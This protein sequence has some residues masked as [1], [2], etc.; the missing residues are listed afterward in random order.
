[1]ATSRSSIFGLARREGDRQPGRCAH[2][3]QAQPPVEPRVRGAVA[4]AG[5]AGERRTFRRSAPSRQHSTGV[6]VDQPGVVG[7]HV[8]VFGEQA[9][10]RLQLH[11]R[12]CAAACCSRPDQADTGT[13]AVE[14]LLGRGAASE[15]RCGEAQQRLHHRQRQQLGV[16]Q[17]RRDADLRAPRPPDPGVP[18]ACHRCRAYSAV[19]RVSRSASMQILQDRVG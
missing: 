11:R 5:P 6:G 15:P 3:V 12:A 7:P 8:G 4:V 17:L 1:M 16:G 19:A 13:D 10:H 2:Q 9:D 14:M 18:S